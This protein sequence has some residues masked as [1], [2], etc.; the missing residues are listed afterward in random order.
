MLNECTFRTQPRRSQARLT[1]AVL[2]CLS[3]GACSWIPKG[4]SALDVGI[5]ER[6]IA[7]WYGAQFHGR[8]AANGEIFNMEAMT[9][10][11]RSLPLGSM[12]RVVNLLNG[13]HVR[14]RINDR[15]PYVN[16]RILDLSHAAAAQLGMVD[17]GV[18]VIQLEVVG[19]HRP[20]FVFDVEVGGNPPI[21]PLTVR[22]LDEPI[23][24]TV[25]PVL[26]PGLDRISS[27]TAWVRRFLPNDILLERRWKWATAGFA[28]DPAHQTQVVL[29]I[30]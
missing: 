29:V 22:K 3:L 26:L 2:V 21:P 18:S 11:H 5:K 6:G 10:A 9:A 17:T 20:E 19:D 16:G 7:S 25:R 28:A 30:A 15:G 8:L 14:V 24:R 27:K 4:E 13:K 12:V 23:S 1:A